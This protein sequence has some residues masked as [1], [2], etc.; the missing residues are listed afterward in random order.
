VSRSFERKGSGTGAG[1]AGHKEVEGLL[2]AALLVCELGLGRL[3]QLGLL[4]KTLTSNRDINS[5]TNS[6]SNFPPR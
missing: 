6:P 1:E 3:G 4:L 2:E 5:L